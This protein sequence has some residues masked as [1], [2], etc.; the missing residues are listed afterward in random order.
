MSRSPQP[1]AKDPAAVYIS[2]LVAPHWK[3]R[4]Q[5][6][7]ALGDL[8]DARAVESLIEALNDSNQWVRIVAAE[9]LGQIGDPAATEA[10]IYALDD[11]SIWVRRAS[12]VAL[13]QIGDSLAISPLIERLLRP[14]NSEW[15]EE[16]HAVIAKALGAIG[17]Q[18]VKALIDTLEDPDIWISSAAAR[19]LG[20]IGDPQAVVPLT[21]L[22]KHESRWVRSATTQALAHIADARAV[23]AALTADE[24]PRAFWKLMAL[25]EIGQSTIKR[26]TELLNDPDEQIRTRASEVLRQLRNKEDTGPLIATLRAERTVEALKDKSPTRQV[27]GHAQRRERGNGQ[28]DAVQQAEKIVSAP[29]APDSVDSLASALQDPVAEVRL[30]AV[31]ALSKVGDAT[32]MDA[33][34]QA[35][36]DK[37]SRVRAAA[38]RA[39]GEIGA[40]LSG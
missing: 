10:L 25:K 23:R 2:A 15:P 37:D 32:V 26:L 38:A 1:G 11:I 29:E 30:A 3:T 40:R 13:G 9:A 36:Q 22:M 35:I 5:A 34:N 20:Q 8:R 18:A 28:G 14:P 12:V 7:Q 31:E 24:A 17:G 39:M 19:A 6:A 16:L 21:D 27:L 4:W 33:L